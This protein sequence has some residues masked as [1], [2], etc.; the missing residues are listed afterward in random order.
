MNSDPTPIT[1]RLARPGAFERPGRGLLNSAAVPGR[2]ARV[3]R[4]FS[5]V[6]LSGFTNFVD[7]YGDDAALAEVSLLRSAIRDVSARYAVRVDKWLG[8]GAMLVG[9]EPEPLVWATLE[10]AEVHRR[11]GVL[12][13]RAGLASGPVI[14]CDGDDYLGRSVNLAAR[15][16]DLAGPGQVLA[17]VSNDL[18]V[19]TE[20]TVASE[21]T[22]RVKGFASTI[23]VQV[24]APAHSDVARRALA[25]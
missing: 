7:L 18:R 21:T 16:S 5:F 24:L 9:V 2:A 3:V 10:A 23:P 15:L 14:M 20:V 22:L 1:A 11:H 8:D 25:Q 4:S 6:D 19:P 12:A 17:A 13:L